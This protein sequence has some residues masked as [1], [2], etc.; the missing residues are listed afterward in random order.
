VLVAIGGGL[1]LVV[2]MVFWRFLSP[3]AVAR[4]SEPAPTLAPAH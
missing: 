1:L 4:G 3:S 2:H